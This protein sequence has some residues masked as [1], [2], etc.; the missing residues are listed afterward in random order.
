MSSLPGLA[1][2]MLAFWTC[3]NS[4]V[5]DLDHRQ[6]HLAVVGIAGKAR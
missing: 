6:R 4:P 1:K 3:F 5:A 2:A